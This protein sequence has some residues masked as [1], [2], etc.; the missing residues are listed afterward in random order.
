MSIDVDRRKVKE[1]TAASLASSAAAGST[2]TAGAV[3]VSAISISEDEW[4]L[5]FL[6]CLACLVLAEAGKRGRGRVCE[7]KKDEDIKHEA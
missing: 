2:A 3:V 5:L 6:L 7:W 1:H 4:T